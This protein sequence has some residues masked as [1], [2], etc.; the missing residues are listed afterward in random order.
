MSLLWADTDRCYSGEQEPGWGFAMGAGSHGRAGE[1]FAPHEY[2]WCMQ[3]TAAQT[4]P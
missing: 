1:T 2:M 4:L 3:I